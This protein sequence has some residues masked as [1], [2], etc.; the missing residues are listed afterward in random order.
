[1]TSIDISYPLTIL[2]FRY[3]TYTILPNSSRISMESS[4][5]PLCIGEVSFISSYGSAKS[6]RLVL[7]VNHSRVA[8]FEILTLYF[9]IVECFE[10]GWKCI[11]WSFYASSIPIVNIYFTLFL[12]YFWCFLWDAWIVVKNCLDL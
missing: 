9:N 8:P 4:I 5:F 6:M 12:K 11:K 1:M 3:L 2:K 10:S 7:F